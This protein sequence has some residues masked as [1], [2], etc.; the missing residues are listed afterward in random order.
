MNIDDS[1]GFLWLLRPLERASDRWM[2]R[3]EVSDRAQVL[4][5]AKG[6]S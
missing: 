2:D 1:E 4:E 3:A 5:A 6:V